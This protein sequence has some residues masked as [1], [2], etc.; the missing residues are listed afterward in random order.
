MYHLMRSQLFWDGNKRTAV[1]MASKLM[2]DHGA[3]LINVP[4]DRWGKWN[5]LIAE[6]YFSNNDQKIV[7]WTYQQAIQGVDFHPQRN[8]PHSKPRRR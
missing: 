7:K 3:G 1:L 8:L 6:F 2:I 5:E 4:L